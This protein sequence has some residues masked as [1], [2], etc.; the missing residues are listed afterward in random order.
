MTMFKTIVQGHTGMEAELPLIHTSR[1]EFLPRFTTGH[2]I[3][4]RHCD[5]FAESLI[6]LFYGRPAYRSENGKGYGEAI[7]LCPICFVFKPNTVSKSV[8]RVFPCDSG[9]VDESKF[10]PDI[11]PSDL[12]DLELQPTIESAQRLVNLVFSTN[13]NYFYGQVELQ[14]AFVNGTLIKRYCDLLERPGPVSFDDRRSAIEIQANQA[15][16]LKDQLMFVVVP[17]EIL[18]DKS[19]RQT[20]SRVWKCDIIEYPTFNGDAPTAYYSVV[21]HEVA[22]RLETLGGL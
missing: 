8:H 12:G 16:S 21:R 13:R 1:C 22:K 10:E 6:Y 17:R 19:I 5:V 3:E 20:I 11:H 15:I 4:A 18:E 2:T 9:A 14:S 7:C